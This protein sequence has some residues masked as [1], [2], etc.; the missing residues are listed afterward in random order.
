[1]LI[2]FLAWQ[3]FSTSLIFRYV[4]RFYSNVYHVTV[5]RVGQKPDCLLR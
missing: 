2:T 3:M 4:F 5:Y 1:M